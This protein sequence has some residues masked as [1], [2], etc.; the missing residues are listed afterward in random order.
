M[1]LK[2]SLYVDTNS[3]LGLLSKRRED[4]VKVLY[5]GVFDDDF[6]LPF[7]VVNRDLET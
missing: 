3:V 2:A 4:G 6:A 5:A 7:F 1:A